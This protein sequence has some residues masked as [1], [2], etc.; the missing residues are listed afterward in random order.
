MILPRLF[1]LLL[2]LFTATA[3]ADGI[4]SDGVEIK[5]HAPPPMTA[6]SPF[7]VSVTAG[8]YETVAFNLEGSTSKEVSGET[9]T[10]QAGPG[11]HRL[12]IVGMVWTKSGDYVKQLQHE[13]TIVVL[14]TTPDNRFNA[15]LIESTAAPVAKAITPPAPARQT[16]EPYPTSPSPYADVSDVRIEWRSRSDCEWCGKW[17][18][19]MRPFF[20]ARGVSVDAPITV[21]QSITAPQFRVVRYGRRTDWAIGYLDEAKFAKHLEK[22]ESTR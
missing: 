9:C 3:I 7:T 17:N 5:S 20:E 14:A 10:F 1:V 2:L 19:D 13:S 4:S 12:R 15:P 8:K 22:L 16:I 21:A 6:V 18:R 11:V